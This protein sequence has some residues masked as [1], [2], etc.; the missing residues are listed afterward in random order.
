MDENLV[1]KN[2]NEEAVGMLLDQV[3]AEV[4]GCNCQRCR[5]DASALALNDLPP[6]YWVTGFGEL[7]ESV[8]CYEAQNHLDIYHAVLR[9]VLRVKANPRH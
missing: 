5:L 1:F 4:E 2:I 9:A 7:M 8:S 3:I 6:R